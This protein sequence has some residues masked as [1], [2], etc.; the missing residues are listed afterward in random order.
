[1]NMGS[2]V[3]SHKSVLFEEAL[4]DL[5]TQDP[6]VELYMK[7]AAAIQNAVQGYCV[8]CDEK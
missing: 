7:L 5:E 1:M 6:N 4:L 3:Q 8:I 2:Q